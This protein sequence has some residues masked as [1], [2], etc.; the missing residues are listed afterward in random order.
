MNAFFAKTHNCTFLGDS[1]WVKT[2]INTGTSF[3]FSQKINKRPC[4]YCSVKQWTN[5]F[6]STWQQA[7]WFLCHGIH[8]CCGWRRKGE[9][10]AKVSGENQCPY[11]KFHGDAKQRLK[12]S[13]GLEY[14][15]WP[16]S[17]TFGT[18]L[19]PFQKDCYLENG[20]EH[21]LHRGTF[22]IMSCMNKE[23]RARQ[24]TGISNLTYKMSSFI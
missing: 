6:K 14:Q 10:L 20:K 19:K 3:P 17:E 15:C 13:M 24:A 8:R 23:V 18:F 5:F 21:C 1:L 7:V 2:L 16:M 9:I 4:N 11:K 22:R 12:H